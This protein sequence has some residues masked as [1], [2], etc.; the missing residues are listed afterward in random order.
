[1]IKG[2]FIRDYAVAHLTVGENLL[3]IDREK[4]D[5]IFEFRYKDVGDLQKGKKKQ[6]VAGIDECR[7]TQ[8]YD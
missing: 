2:I 3:Q 4:G 7:N 6:R 5:V 1:L 8:Q